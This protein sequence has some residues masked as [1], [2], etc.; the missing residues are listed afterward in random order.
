[1]NY[2]QPKNSGNKANRQE[3]RVAVTI[4]CIEA[5]K[6]RFS[7]NKQMKRLNDAIKGRKF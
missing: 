1:M 7:K 5:D 3:P 4:L 2:N 6:E